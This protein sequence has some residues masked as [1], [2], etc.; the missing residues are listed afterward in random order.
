MD[1]KVDRRTTVRT[2]VTVDP[3]TVAALVR[4]HVGAPANADTR[5][6]ASCG[7]LDLVQVEW[8]VTSDD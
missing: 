2:T 5:F 8:T 3:D 6:E 7:E 4:Q 1:V